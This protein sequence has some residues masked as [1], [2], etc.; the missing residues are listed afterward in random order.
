MLTMLFMIL[1]FTVFGK[2]L[3]FAFRMTW[4]MMKLI[5]MIMIVPVIIVTIAGGLFRIALPVLLIIGI[6]HLLRREAA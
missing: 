4:S 1:F 6:V 3:G 2:L 5:L